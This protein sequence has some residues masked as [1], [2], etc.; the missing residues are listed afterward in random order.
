MFGVTHADVAACLL[1]H[2]GYPYKVIQAVERHH[3][4][5][6]RAQTVLTPNGVVYLAAALT[7][8]AARG[9]LRFRGETANTVDAE[10][11]A[12]IGATKTLAKWEELAERFKYSAF[13]D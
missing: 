7:E 8:S 2:W 13:K 12:S 3:K 9:A 4:R 10:Y 1:A 11:V 5:P 6:P